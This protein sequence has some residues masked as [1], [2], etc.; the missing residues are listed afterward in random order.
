MTFFPYNPRKV[1]LGFLIGAVACAGLTGWALWNASRGA[2][3]YGEARGG[4]SAGLM[5]AFLQIFPQLKADAG[6]NEQPSRAAV[7]L[8]AGFLL[9]WV[10]FLFV[11]WNRPRR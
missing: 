5:F 8:I 4:V 1:R 6:L 10:P 11:L 7:F 3:T 2:E 9:S